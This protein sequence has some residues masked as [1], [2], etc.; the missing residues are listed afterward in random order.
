MI[1]NSNGY[2]ITDD[3]K[4]LENYHQS[5]MDRIGAMQVIAD[6]VQFYIKK[7]D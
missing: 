4:E 1:A 7:N 2:K 3:S 5:L 6:Q